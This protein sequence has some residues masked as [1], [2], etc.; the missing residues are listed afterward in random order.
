[1]LNCVQKW[2]K[3]KKKSL[4]NLWLPKS[5]SIQLWG[6]NTTSLTHLTLS[7][8]ANQLH[9]LQG[10]ITKREVESDTDYVVE[11]F[12]GPSPTPPL[13]DSSQEEQLAY[14]V[15]EVNAT[16]ATSIADPLITGAEKDDGEIVVFQRED[17]A[18]VNQVCGIGVVAVIAILFV[19]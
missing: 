16:G 9:H 3:S 10:L 19:V 14:Q 11:S 5:P 12:I 2:D 17:G 13:Q 4:H 7:A 18:F 6:L 15:E 1:M 8:D